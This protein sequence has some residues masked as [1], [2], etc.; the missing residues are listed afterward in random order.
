MV[1]LGDWECRRFSNHAGVGNLIRMGC[2]SPEHLKMIP[3]IT[4]YIMTYDVFLLLP[5]SKYLSSKIHI[6][7]GLLFPRLLFCFPESKL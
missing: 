1:L 4:V 6:F 3:R 7:L 5:S 2:I